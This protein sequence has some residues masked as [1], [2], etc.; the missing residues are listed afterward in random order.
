M[1]IP[2]ERLR[3]HHEL[4]EVAKAFFEKIPHELRA[5]DE[6]LIAHLRPVNMFVVPSCGARDAAFQNPNKG[7]AIHDDFPTNSCQIKT[8][9]HKPGRPEDGA[10]WWGPYEYRNPSH[11]VKPPADRV[12][13]QIAPVSRVYL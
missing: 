11:D 12:F 7:V 8:N 5:L 2:I 9:S 4:V 3:S 10:S 1:N 13:V 6:A